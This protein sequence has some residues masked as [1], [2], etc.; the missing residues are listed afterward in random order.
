MGTLDKASLP[1]VPCPLP[2]PQHQY[3]EGNELIAIKQ[4]PAGDSLEGRAGR[5]HCFCEQ[6]EPGVREV[7]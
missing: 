2:Q 3:R 6:P 5:G 7:G 4:V 1:R